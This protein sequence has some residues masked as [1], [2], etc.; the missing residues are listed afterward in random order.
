VRVRLAAALVIMSASLSQA[1]E[2]AVTLTGTDFNGGPAFE[3]SIGSTIVG[4]GRLDPIPPAGAGKTFVFDVPDATLAA[5]G[6]LGVRMT[7]DAFEAGVGD[8]NLKVLGASIAG[9]VVDLSDFRVVR[10]GE[11]LP[12]RESGSLWNNSDV[13][14]ASPPAGGWTR[15]TTPT[16][17]TAPAAATGAPA[18]PTAAV[19]CK[20]QTVAVLFSVNETT[21]SAANEK[22]LGDAL[23]AADGCHATIT[24][25][26]STTGS[27]AANLRVSAARA[28]VVVDYLVEEG[29]PADAATASGR[30]ETRRFGL[31]DASNRRVVVQFANPE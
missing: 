1:A 18:Q 9:N 17:E 27:S 24:G 19:T 2:V 28:Q 5:G 21:L 11:L 6:D 29:L 25:Y 26:S 16:A 15:A 10:A 8:R 4:T 31:G 14:L 3:V 30:G 23:A 22:L 20:P 12:T 13:A 7:N